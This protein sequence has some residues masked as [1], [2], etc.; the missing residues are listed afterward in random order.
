MADDPK[1]PA[2]TMLGWLPNAPQPAQPQGQPP[3]NQGQQGYGQPP[4]GYGQ[5]GYGQPQQNYGQQQPQ[6][7]PQQEY[8][9]PQ[10]PQGYGQQGSGQP[11][12]GQPQQPQ[13]SYG[14][15]GYG[16]PGYG[17]P[18]QPQQSY[19]QQGYGQQGY[20]QPQQPQGF[21]YSPQ[22]YPQQSYPQQPA[23]SAHGYPQAPA[24]YQQGYGGY[25]Q[26]AA[27]VSDP[28]MARPIPDANATAGVS[29][30]VSFIRATYA[31]L[32]GAILAFAGLLYLL[33]TNETVAL[34][35]SAP[36]IKF[37]LG[38]RFNWVIVLGAFV[39]VSWIADY[40]ASHATSRATQYLGLAIYVVAQALI[41]LPLLYIVAVKTSEIVARTGHEPHILRDAAYTTL[42]IFGALTASVFITK[43]DFS[44]LRS[45]LIMLSG[46]AMALIALSLLFGFN[47]GIAFSIGMVVLAAGY[48]LYQTSQVL[49]HYDPRQYVAAALALFSSVALMFWYVI[50]IFLRMRQ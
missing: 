25:G 46:A 32:L 29:D 22:G 44:F 48:I 34:K 2:K 10:Q 36:I 50:R 43:K 19:G 28:R 20:G 31:H 13:Q 7:Y 41:F 39:A 17:Q 33:T 40:W 37:A 8:G 16:Q 49:A 15:Q 14:Q 26:A 4:Q 35:V 21:G 27:A 6:N 24:G 45:G 9:Q 23:A 12:Y 47:L 42:A 30:R 3:P 38:G 1:Q 18:Q 5:Q 11:G